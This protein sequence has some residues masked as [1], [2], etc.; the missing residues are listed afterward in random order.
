MNYKIIACDVAQL[1]AELSYD[2]GRTEGV[3]TGTV[4]HYK[5]C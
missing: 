1:Y 5:T 2:N 3:N 4:K